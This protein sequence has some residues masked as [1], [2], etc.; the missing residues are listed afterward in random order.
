MLQSEVIGFAAPEGVMALGVDV[1]LLDDRAV[2][3]CLQGV[4]NAAVQWSS[5]GQRWNLEFS[6]QNLGFV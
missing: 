1:A 5:R 4:G 2:L 6:V 3:H